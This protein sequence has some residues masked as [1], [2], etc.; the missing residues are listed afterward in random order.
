M[1]EL[2]DVNEEPVPHQRVRLLVAYDGGAFSGFARNDGVTTVAGELETHLRRVLKHE[3][4]VTGAGR[5][6]KGVHAWGQVVTFDTFA[7]R[8]EPERLQRSLNSVCGPAISVREITLV[9]STFDARFSARW[10]RYRYTILNSPTPNPFLGRYAWHLTDDLSIDA[11]ND[12]GATLVGQH[13][14]S[15]FCR[16]P[17]DHHDGTPVSLIREVTGLQWTRLDDD[18]VRLEITARA[19]CHQMVRSI[20]GTL[21]AVGRARFDVADVAAILAARD[22]SAA[23]DLAPP[24]GLCLYEVGY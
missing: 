9:D 2:I 15:S 3:V 12:G 22:R 19:F 8:L 21:V 24:H 16:R 13:D 10:R 23:G 5:T 6:D 4:V 1:P 18:L 11:M 7:D 20:V 17:P 14:F